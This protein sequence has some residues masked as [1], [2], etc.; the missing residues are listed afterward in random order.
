LTALR[1]L[2]SLASGSAAIT[3]TIN[4]AIMAKEDMEEKTRYNEK[5]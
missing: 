5:I 2:G 4:I 1:A 3:K